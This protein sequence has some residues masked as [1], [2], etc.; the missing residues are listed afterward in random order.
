MDLNNVFDF[1]IYFNPNTGESLAAVKGSRD[2]A[3]QVIPE[4][5]MDFDRFKLVLNL[6]CSWLVAG[7]YCGCLTGYAK[8]FA[9]HF[10]VFPDIDTVIKYLPRDSFPNLYVIM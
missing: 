5:T 2:V 4:T 6:N 9:E 10:G 8:R 1:E 3:L 7:Y